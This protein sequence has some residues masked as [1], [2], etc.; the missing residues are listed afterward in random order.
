MPLNQKKQ[1]KTNLLLIIGIIFVL[2]VGI[3]V[4][5]FYF[6]HQEQKCVTN[7]LIYGAKQLENQYGYEFVGSGFLKTPPNVKPPTIFFNSTTSW[8]KN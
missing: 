3:F 4:M 1:Q 2:L 6:S 5:L 7:P 8:S